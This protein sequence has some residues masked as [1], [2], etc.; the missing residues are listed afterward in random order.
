MQHGERFG[1]H[2]MSYFLFK[3]CEGGRDCRSYQSTISKMV[4]C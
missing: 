3:D 4:S 1:K 2:G